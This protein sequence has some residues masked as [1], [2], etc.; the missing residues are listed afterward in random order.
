MIETGSQVRFLEHFSSLEDP[1]REESV[2][3]PISEML[4][5]CLCAVISGAEHWTEIAL[6]GK[7]RLDYLRQFLPFEKGTPSHDTLGDFFRR[8][9]PGAFQKCFIAWVESLQNGLK[10]FIA[11]DGKKIRHSFDG[12]QEA[13]HLVSAWSSE[14]QVILGQEKVNKKSNEITAIPKLLELLVLEGSI[15]TIDAM[16]CQ[17]NIAQNI[18]DKKA[19]YVLAL[20]GNQSNLCKDVEAFLNE[21]HKQGFRNV[22]V[23]SFQTR[24]ADHGRIEV[25]TYYLSSD[26]EWL[27]ALH[28][29]WKD[30]NSIGMVIAE[31]TDKK[32]QHTSVERRYY[33]SSLNGAKVQQFAAAVRGHWGVESM[34]WI[35]DVLF[36]SDDSRIRKDHAP[37]NF[38]VIQQMAINLT[39]NFKMGKISLK[40]KL[41]KA[42][43]IPEFLTEILQGQ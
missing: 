33:I 30:L 28:P 1:R 41:K 38:A 32:T 21:Q 13:I 37:Q 27:Q 7:S 31:R 34:H 8:L 24:D 40:A 29:A 36:G 19:D 26:V 9:E 20:K 16:G 35:M 12:N 18:R 10:S 39:K 14:Q 23:A 25:R 2:V 5:L 6:Y 42:A 15:I 22:P 43:W 4:L 17:K 11:I 3:Y